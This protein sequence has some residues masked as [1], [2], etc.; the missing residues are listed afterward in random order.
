MMKRQGGRGAESTSSY[1]YAREFGL[2][3]SAR[4]TFRLLVQ[5]QPVQARLCSF[6]EKVDRRPIDPP[7]I[8]QLVIPEDKEEWLNPVSPCRRVPKR[9][10]AAHSKLMLLVLLFTRRVHC[11]NKQQTIKLYCQS[12]HNT[13]DPTHY[14]DY[15]QNPY[16]F[17]Y[18]S[19]VTHDSYQELNFVNGNRTTAGTV[20]QSLHRLK[21]VD[22]TDGGFF[23]FPDMSVR[24]EGKYRIKFSLFE[25]TGGEVMQVSSVYS[26]IFTVYSPKLFPGMS[27]STFLTRS[28]SD[29]GVRIRIRKENR[30][31]HT[32][33]KRSEEADDDGTDEDSRSQSS[34]R[35]HSPNSAD[36]LSPSP[37]SNLSFAT[38]IRPTNSSTSSRSGA[39]SAT[40]PGRFNQFVPYCEEYAYTQQSPP[41]S[42]PTGYP[43]L[44]HTTFSGLTLSDQPP[45][46]DNDFAAAPLF[47]P[48]P[49]TSASP[50]LPPS[51][52]LP[53]P[54]F[55]QSS[56]P[57]NPQERKQAD[58]FFTT[59]FT[60]YAKQ[61]RFGNSQAVR[62]V[63]MAGASTPTTGMER[64]DAGVEWMPTGL[65]SS[66]PSS[67]MGFST[68]AVHH[69]SDFAGPHVIH[70]VFLP[71][72]QQR[73]CSHQEIY[74][75]R[76]RSWAGRG[77]G[78]SAQGHGSPYGYS[79]RATSTTFG[80]RTPSTSSSLDHQHL[81]FGG[82][83]HG[84][85]NG[86]SGGSAVTSSGFFGPSSAPSLSGW[87]RPC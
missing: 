2:E 6:K 73:L 15:L 79:S 85:R 57:R 51:A 22:N 66:L 65:S 60:T 13:S 48:L 83:H 84:D 27:E 24:V 21:N 34:N 8:V 56:S 1:L 31:L 64:A 4:R 45:L 72:R 54:S 9:S 75:A 7:P 55:I 11:T 47:P 23:I 78:G 19:I 69:P 3:D 37:T 68:N 5:Q 18:A 26:E 17:M 33:R 40:A 81:Y 49:P 80:A 12:L 71:S 43:I 44:D 77:L 25:I 86:G 39:G 14:R 42:S 76:R 63:M 50:R 58:G 29:Q 59:L 74:D 82:P 30:T 46:P 53:P 36:S 67:A 52:R 62:P 32:R 16:F 38:N 20:V 28:F 70:Q 61:H 10:S 35:T 87:T 41:S